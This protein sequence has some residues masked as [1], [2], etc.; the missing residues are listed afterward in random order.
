MAISKWIGGVIILIAFIF[1]G[2]SQAGEIPNAIDLHQSQV[3][4]ESSHDFQVL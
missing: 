1:A 3:S 4:S 2:R